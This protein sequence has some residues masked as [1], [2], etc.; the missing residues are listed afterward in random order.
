MKIPSKK[1]FYEHM[2]SIYGKYNDTT[3]YRTLL[4]IFDRADD[5]C[6]MNELY[7]LTDYNKK[8]RLQY[9]Y[10]LACVGKEFTP[11]QVDQY[12]SIIEYAMENME[13]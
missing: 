7:E 12:I 10:G 9:R 8:Q 11:L 13:I 6:L 2:S 3:A 4:D 1:N 5:V